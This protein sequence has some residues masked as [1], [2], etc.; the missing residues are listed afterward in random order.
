[1]LLFLKNF[2]YVVILFNG[3]ERILSPEREPN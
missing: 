2:H 1:M 3:F